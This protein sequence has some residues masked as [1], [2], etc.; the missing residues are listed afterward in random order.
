M[1]QSVCPFHKAARPLVDNGYSI[2]PD[3]YKD[4]KTFV[5]SWTQYCRVKPDNTTLRGWWDS[6]DKNVSVCLGPSSNIVA[7]DFDYDVDGLHKRIQSIMGRYLVAKK[8]S[9]GFTAFFRYNKEVSKSWAKNGEVVV[10]LLSDNKKTTLPPSVH[11]KGMDYVYTTEH[12]LENTKPEEL[13]YL[14]TN[15]AEKLD[16]LF[17]KTASHSASAF[18]VA[19]IKEAL[20]HISSDDYHTWIKVGMAL[21]NTFEDDGYAVWEEWSSESGKFKENEALRKWEGFESDDV[22]VATIFYLAK[23]EGWEQTY[24]NYAPPPSTVYDISKTQETLSQ[25]RAKGRPIGVKTGVEPFDRLLHLRRGELTILTGAPNSGKSELLDY[26]IYSTVVENGLSAMMVSYEKETDP[27]VES[28]LHR[29]AGKSFE[30]R[31]DQED[32]QLLADLKPMVSFV[33]TMT[34]TKDVDQ[35]IRDAERLQKDK[36]LDILCIDPYSYLESVDKSKGE[37]YHANYVT[38]CLRNFARR[39]GVHV[40][41]VAHPRTLETKKGEI[42]KISLYSISGGSAFY[43]NTDNG[44]IAYRDGYTIEVDIAKVRHQDQDTCGK[45]CMEFNKATRSFTEVEMELDL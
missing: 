6:G 11:P 40:F 4:N 17:D 34:Y 30:N 28:F 26:L 19:R 35:I 16:R 12:T 38:K 2:I 44:I 32:R 23:E 39:S 8:G 20:G 10:E 37:F 24:T 7:V 22:T 13:P 18:D 31:T 25:W 45:F 27:H 43:N 29:M 33:D 41:L 9:K 42:P 36:G 14:P 15:F 21:K 3:E 1:E 5:K